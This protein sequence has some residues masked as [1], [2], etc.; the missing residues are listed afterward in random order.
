LT[1]L[2]CNIKDLGEAEGEA[3]LTTAKQGLNFDEITQLVA[4]AGRE[5][6]MPLG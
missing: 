5:G 3:I 6:E 4:F 2:A 1:A